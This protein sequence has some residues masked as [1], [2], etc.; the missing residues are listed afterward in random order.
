MSEMA[1]T[2][3][4]CVVAIAATLLAIA[5]RSTNVTVTKDEEIGTS[6]FDEFKDPLDA[7]SL[8]IVKYD[9]DLGEQQQFRVANK[10][11]L[12]VIPSH[13]D[14]PA[15]AE[16]RIRDAAENFVDLNIINVATDDPREHGVFGVVEPD[17]ESVSDAEGGVGV[18]V[19]LLDSGGK[20]LA[21]LVIGKQVKGA[22]EQRFVR[23]PDKDRVYVVKIDPEKLPA[24]FHDWINKDLLDLNSWDIEQIQLKDYSTDTKATF[25]GRLLID[26]EQRLSVTLREESGD[27]EF[28]EFLEFR[29]GELRPTELLEGEELNDERLNTMRDALDDL[30]I[31]NVSRKPIGLGADLKADK[32]FVND[33]ESVNSLI[34]RGFYPTSSGG[35]DQIELLSSDGEGKLNRWMF[36]TARAQADK[37]PQ[38][39]LETV[40]EDVP[41]DSGADA[42]AETSDEEESV[43][44][45]EKESER[46][47]IVTE[48]KRKMDE[49]QEKVDKLDEDVQKLNYRFADWY[50][51]ISEDVFKKIRLGRSDI[52]K[53]SEDAK[54]EGFGVDALQSI[55]KEG[56]NRDDAESEE[57]DKS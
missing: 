35:G 21:H 12:W 19:N 2:V 29:G 32:G 24:K 40:P 14:Y 44:E 54:K 1:K 53:E 31:V 36:V 38:P 39:E 30:E 16:N 25:D 42:D 51:V 57:D 6:L 46:D 20:K 37:H 15:D 56:L 43:E 45:D 33:Q 47:R 23:V 26:P 52:I 50:Y 41:E 13:D 49:W 48:N 28:D 34:Q 4:F 55:E 9:E 5:N 7:R 3:V 11:G 10:N 17:E 18:L 8:E 27:W 22:E